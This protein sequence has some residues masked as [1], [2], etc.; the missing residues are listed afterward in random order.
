MPGYTD[1]SFDLYVPQNWDTVSALPLLIGFHG[2]G[3]NRRST[4]RLTCPGGDEASPRCL[5][6]QALSRGYAVVMPDGVGTRPFRGIRTW[7]AGGGKNGFDC[8]SGG[9]CR[10]GA[11]D[12][13]YVDDLLAEVESLVRVDRR[14]IHATGMS[15]GGAMSHRLAC[16]R[17]AV[18]AAIA[19]VGGA[20][21]FAAVGGVCPGRVSVLQIHGTEDPCWTFVQSDEGCIEAGGLRA[22]VM[23]SLLGWGNRN[24]CAAPVET[25]LPDRDP[26]DGTRAFQLQWQACERSVE[27]IRI[28]GGGH[29]WP[30]GYQYLGQDK[31]GRASGDLETNVVILDFFDAN[32][33]P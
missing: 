14:R 28:E 29:T 32:P 23:D 7:N 21:Q 31:I 27:L 15:N 17:P 25:P 12:V 8:T 4:E 5:V 6:A 22:G 20:N 11:D 9:A 16:E 1:R 33:R 13:G 26:A 19:A 10:S 3:G 2:G 24:G 18:F 30:N